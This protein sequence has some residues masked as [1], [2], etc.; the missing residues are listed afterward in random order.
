MYEHP[1]DVINTKEDKS[2]YSPSGLQSVMDLD[3]APTLKLPHFEPS[4]P[5]SLPRINS[6]TL[7]D[8]LN[9]K[10][11]EAYGDKYVI[12]CRFEY[13]YEGGHIDGALNFCEKEQLA[14]RLFANVSGT[15]NTLLILHCEY[16]AHRAPLM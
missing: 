11:D 13:E 7:I 12:D 3:D 15:T 10:Y 1:G 8:V 14:D 2:E 16:S 9:G 4:E 5:D 6:E